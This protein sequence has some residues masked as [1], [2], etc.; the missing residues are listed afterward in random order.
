LTNACTYFNDAG[1]VSSWIDHVLSSKA[2]DNLVYEVDVLLDFITSDHKPV[3]VVFNN[4]RYERSISTFP[5]NGTV[6]YNESLWIGRRQT[7]SV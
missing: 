3:T 2:V 6:S 5:R 7:C 1:N 4:L